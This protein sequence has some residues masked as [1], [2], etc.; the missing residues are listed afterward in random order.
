[1]AQREEI[2]NLRAQLAEAKAFRAR[3]VEGLRCACSAQCECGGRGPHDGCCAACGVWHLMQDR[4]AVLRKEVPDSVSTEVCVIEDE[5]RA[6][7]E[8]RDW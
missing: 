1:M 2:A 4:L 5:Q 3:V 6:A 7:L 8:R